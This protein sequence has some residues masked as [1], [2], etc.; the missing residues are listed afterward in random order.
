MGDRLAGDRLLR[1]RHPGS[2][3]PRNSCRRSPGRARAPRC[4]RPG[5]RRSPRRRRRT[6]RTP[7]R[8]GG[9]PGSCRA[10]RGRSSARPGWPGRSPGR[11]SRVVLWRVRATPPTAFGSSASSSRPR[12]ASRS[13]RARPSARRSA[14]GRSIPPDG[15][16][17]GGTVRRPGRGRAG[18]RHAVVHR[19]GHLLEVA[20][21]ERGRD[22]QD[23]DEP[24][25][26]DVDRGAAVRRVLGREGLVAEGR[27]V[28]RVRAARPPW[29]T[30]GSG[31]SRGGCRR[32]S[33]S[34]GGTACRE[35]TRRRSPV[36]PSCCPP[37]RRRSCRR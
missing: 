6:R 8:S 28:R 24:A 16:A 9:R 37:R 11:S 31:S 10:C 20:R 33:R 15:L 18:G 14:V 4:P 13:R 27:D 1:G 5:R 36:R 3:R 2:G 35:R 30:R 32:R 7:P 25:P 17:A 22:D 29:P 26:P 12:R 19:P 21:I 34:P 23:G